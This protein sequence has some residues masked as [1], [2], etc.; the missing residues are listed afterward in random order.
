M[1]SSGEARQ[2]LNASGNL[3]IDY[4]NSDQNNWALTMLDDPNI[5]TI[6]DR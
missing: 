6:D 2:K 1:K 5:R 3:S 4:Q